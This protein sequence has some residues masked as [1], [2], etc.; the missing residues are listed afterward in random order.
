M[1]DLGFAEITH[2]S[3]LPAALLRD[4]LYALDDFVVGF[5]RLRKCRV[6]LGAC[7]ILGVQGAGEGA[8]GERGPRD[9]TNAV[10]LAVGEHFTFLQMM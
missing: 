5:I 9:D 3:H 10:V 2:L 7:G 8:S 1:Q 4:F 6:Q